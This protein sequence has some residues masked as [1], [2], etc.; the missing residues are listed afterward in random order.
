MIGGEVEKK[1]FKI[2]TYCLIL[3]RKA[4]L[5]R[6][7]EDGRRE[8]Y[9]DVK[10]SG[11]IIRFLEK[12]PVIARKV[13]L[14]IQQLTFG[15][16]PARDLYQRENIERG[17]EHVWAIK[18][19]RGRKNPRIY[20]QQYNLKDRQIF[21]VVLSELLEKKKTQKPGHRERAIIRRVAGYNYEL[22]EDNE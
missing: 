7:S 12:E 9:I 20:C 18:P 17:C 13:Y 6:R 8:V 22:A 19:A 3:F 21:V 10:N 2:L 15:Y 14:V 16:K 4:V 1:S 11:H 5:Y